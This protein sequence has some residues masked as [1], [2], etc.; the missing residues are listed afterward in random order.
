VTLAKYDRLYASV[1][2]V[3]KASKTSDSDALDACSTKVQQ[4]HRLRLTTIDLR[5]PA[6]LHQRPS[7]TSVPLDGKEKVYGSIP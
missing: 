6:D 7:T 3:P 5:R 1:P 4:P 2:L